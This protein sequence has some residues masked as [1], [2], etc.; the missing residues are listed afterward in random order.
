MYSKTRAY[1]AAQVSQIR[2]LLGHAVACPNR[3]SGPGAGRSLTA[4]QLKTAQAQV[5]SEALTGLV[6]CT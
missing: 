3:S 5:G 4:R 2:G 1:R 6:P